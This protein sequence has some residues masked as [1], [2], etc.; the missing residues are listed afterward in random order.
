MSSTFSNERDHLD[1]LRI[2]AYQLTCMLLKRQLVRHAEEN[3][4]T[5]TDEEKEEIK[6]K[7][8]NL[9][10]MEEYLGASWETIQQ[11]KKE[12][13]N[14]TIHQMELKKEIRELKEQLSLWKRKGTL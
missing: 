2:S 8:E 7:Y 12:S 1:G 10:G 4:D 3:K 14:H 5:L 9:K 11:L 13:L 6:I